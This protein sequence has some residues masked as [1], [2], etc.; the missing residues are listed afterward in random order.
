VRAPLGVYNMLESRDTE[1]GLL[2]LVSVLLGTNQ[3]PV[4]TTLIPLRLHM[5]R[6]NAHGKNVG[7]EF[8]YDTILRGIFG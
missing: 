4:K 8:N 6:F 7:T 5:V 3:D 1:S 2:L